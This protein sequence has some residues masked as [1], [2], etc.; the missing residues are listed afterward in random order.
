MKIP[1]SSRLIVEELFSAYRLGI[2]ALA[3]WRESKKSRKK[4]NTVI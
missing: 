4:T 2:F 1:C 3:T